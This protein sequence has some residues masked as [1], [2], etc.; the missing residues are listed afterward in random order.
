MK[1]WDSPDPV[2]SAG[3]IRRGGVSSAG[4]MWGSAGGAI[5]SSAHFSASTSAPSCEICDREAVGAKTS[6]AQYQGEVGA[7]RRSNLLT[8][9]TV[10]SNRNVGPPSGL[11]RRSTVGNRRAAAP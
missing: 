1:Q 8:L 9:A 11:E 5:A 4:A 3:R 6:F 2:V 10:L 7:S